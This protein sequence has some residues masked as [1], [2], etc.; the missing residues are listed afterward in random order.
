MACGARE[1]RIAKDQA[2]RDLLWKGRKNAFGAVGR[3]SPF[4]YV[5]DGVVP[6]TQIAPTLRYIHEVGEKYGL[7]ISNIFHAG[8]GN[9]HPLILYDANDPAQA[10]KAEKAGEEVLEL[11]VAVGGCLT[12]EHGV[13]IEKRDLMRVQFSPTDLAV[14]M[15]IKT[16]FD[17]KWLL[18]EAKV[19]PLDGRDADTL[20][21]CADTARSHAKEEGSNTCRFYDESMRR[22]A[23]EAC[24]GDH[25]V[26]LE[27]RTDLD[28]GDI[29]GAIG[30]ANCHPL[31]TRRA[32]AFEVTDDTVRHALA[33]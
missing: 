14:Q 32:H 11:C 33:G 18:N 31:R 20:L 7:T 4:Y 8:D 16:V 26:T 3:L 22:R 29:R 21:R 30:P 23:I 27:N 1:F 15:R 25:R 5:Q 28:R 9:L 13:G 12:G 6:R 17:P 24:T 10:E 2:E 19:F